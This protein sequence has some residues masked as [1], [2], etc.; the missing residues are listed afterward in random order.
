MER[1]NQEIAGSFF[2]FLLVLNIGHYILFL[3][4]PVSYTDFISARKFLRNKELCQH[5]Q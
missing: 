1:M 5:H 2:P 3:W 4:K